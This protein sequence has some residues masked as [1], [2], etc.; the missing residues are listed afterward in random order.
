VSLQGAAPAPRTYEFPFDV[1]AGHAAFFQPLDAELIKGDRVE[2]QSITLLDDVGAAFGTLG[3]PPGNRRPILM[4]SVVYVADSPSPVRFSRG[5]DTNLLP[6]TSWTKFNAGFDVLLDPHGERI[7]NSGNHAEIELSVNGASPQVIVLPFD[8]KQGKSQPGGRPATR[9][10]FTKEDAIEVRRLDLF[11]PD[12]HRFATLGMKIVSPNEHGT[13][14]LVE[15][16][17]R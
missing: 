14:R 8:V 7:N 16:R 15:I 11:D 17:V 1:E 2:V 4:S 9:L 6:N 12:G 13:A 10:P 5:G 3:A